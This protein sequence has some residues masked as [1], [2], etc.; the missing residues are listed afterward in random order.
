MG[1]IEKSLVMADAAADGQKR[2]WLL[3]TLR[4]YAHQRRTASG[5]L[6]EV[7]RRQRSTIWNGPRRPLGICD[8]S[9]CLNRTERKHRKSGRVWHLQGRPR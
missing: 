6:D 3:V 5:D 7:R 8:G 4:E 2:D 1:L 9:R